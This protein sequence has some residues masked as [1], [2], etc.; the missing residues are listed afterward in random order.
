MIYVITKGE[1]SDYHI[2]AVANTPERAEELRKMYC[3]IRND[4]NIEEFEENVPS[5]EWYI[6][7]PTE[8]YEIEFNKKGEIIDIRTYYDEPN[9]NIKF[10]YSVYEKYNRVTIF[11]ITAA[12]EA[13]A[14]KIAID[15]RAKKLA[16]EY[17]L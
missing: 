10:S 5:E 9:Q 13:H 7:T 1:Y 12:D 14:R 2:C 6:L 3:D 15:Y 8:Y 11:N 16:E 17:G 4:A